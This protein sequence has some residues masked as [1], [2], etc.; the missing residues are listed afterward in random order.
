MIYQMCSICKEEPGSHSF[1]FYGKTSDDVYMY[2]TCPADAT[3]Y[4]D[5][6]GILYHYEEVLEQNNNKKW[7]W[8]FDCRDFGIKHSLE[9][10]TAIGIIKILKKYEESLCQI[11]IINANAIIKGF[12]SFI[13]PFLSKQIVDKIIWS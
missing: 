8:I 6:Q 11:Q 12:Y 4:W 5:T 3:K 9:I 2:Y 1:D 10:T 13:Y 7:S